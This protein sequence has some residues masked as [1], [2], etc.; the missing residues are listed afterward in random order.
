VLAGQ[1]GCYG[2]RLITALLVRAGWK[3]G[4]DRVERIYTPPTKTCLW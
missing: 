3:V 4:K 2:Y 1:Y